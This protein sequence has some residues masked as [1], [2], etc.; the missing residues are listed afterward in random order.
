MTIDRCVDAC[1]ASGFKLAG[2]EYGSEC[3]CG[4]TLQGEN[5]PVLDERCDI[6][7]VGSK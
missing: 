7:C 2:L 3:Y 1:A 4:N 5:V 6:P